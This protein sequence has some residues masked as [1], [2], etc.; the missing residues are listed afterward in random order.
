M[1]TETEK[2]GLFKYDPSTDGAST[3]NIRQALNEN[4]DK[5]DQNAKEF[6]SALSEIDQTI[7]GL[8][9]DKIGAASNPN[10]LDNWYFA[11]PINQRGQTSYSGSLYGID[12][13]RVNDATAS[14]VNGLVLVPTSYNNNLIQ[15]IEPKVWN[16]LAGKTVTLSFLASDITGYWILA[17]H[18]TALKTFG[19]TGVLSVTYKVPYG[20]EDTFKFVALCGGAGASVTPKAAKLELGSQQTLAHQDADGNWVLNDPPPNKALE[21]AKC[22]QYFRV[23]N[24]YSKFLAQYID[25]NK[26]VFAFPE[27][28]RSAPSMSGNWKIYSGYTEQSGFVFNTYQTGNMIFVEAV[29]ENHGLSSAWLGVGV[30]A[31]AYLSADL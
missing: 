27:I 8:S 31:N 25:G 28:M 15:M 21:L 7:A 10:L 17:S 18:N 29:K 24:A 26:V 1:S 9:P 16:A 23:F 5:I 19:E 22:Q 6:S 30:D 13:W 14:L 4:W 3:F 12:R 11:D 20:I 2:L